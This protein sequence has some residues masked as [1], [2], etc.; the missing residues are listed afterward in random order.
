MNSCVG[1][2]ITLGA[3]LLFLSLAHMGDQLSIIAKHLEN[4]L[5][6]LKLR[7]L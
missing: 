4:I 6:Q 2:S 1:I 7:K 5:E 3:F